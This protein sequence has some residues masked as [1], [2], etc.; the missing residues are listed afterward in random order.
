MLS[1]LQLTPEQQLEAIAKI[2][3]RAVVQHLD[4]S[5]TD[6]ENLSESGPSPLEVATET[7]LSVHRG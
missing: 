6:S 4:Q 2:L 1:D 5:A 7:R 3:A